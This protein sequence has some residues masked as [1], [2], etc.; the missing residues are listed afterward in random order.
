MVNLMARLG[1][2]GRHNGANAIVHL[3]REVVGRRR[4][5]QNATQEVRNAV[6]LDSL[7]DEDFRALDTTVSERT[8]SDR[9]F[10]QTLARLTFA[11]ARAKGF[12]RC[13]VDAAL[14]LDSLIPVDDPAHERDKLLRDAYN[15]AQKA[16]YIR[17]G[18]LALGRLGRRAVEAGDLER[19]RVLLHQQLDLGPEKDD[20]AAEVDSA[21]VLGDI[22]RRENDDDQAQT[23]YRRAGAAAERLEYRQ[24]VAEALVRQI[25]TTPSA[26]LET[27]AALQHQA[28]DAAQRTGDQSLEAR[29]LVGLADTLVESRRLDDATPYYRS[30]L[31]IARETGDLALEARSVTAL[32]HAFRE[33]GHTLDAI[34]AERAALG[35]EERLGNRQAA[36]NWALSLG[37]SELRL[38]N[39]ESAIEAFERARLLGNQI[40]DESIEQ[41]AEGNLGIANTLLGRGSETIEHLGRAIDL[42]RR[43]GD[44]SQEAQWVSSLGEAYWMFGQIDDAI[45]V[46]NDAIT[47]AEATRSIAMQADSFALLGQIYAAQRE[48]I[49]ARDCYTRAL[50]LNRDLGQTADQVT[51]LSA[52]ALLAANAGQFTQASQLFDQALQLA[53]SSNDRT[54]MTVLFGR[55]GSLAQKR[56]DMR[57]ALSN[58]QRA[59]ESA[60]SVGDTRLLSRALQYLATAQDVMGDL[61]AVTT[62][63]RAVTAADDASD[64]RGGISMR[65]N[66][67]MLIGRLP[68]Q[69]AA[70]DAIGWLSDAA[71]YAMEAG[72]EYTELRRQA[73]ELIQ[74]LGGGSNRRFVENNRPGSGLDYGSAASDA[75]RDRHRDEDNFLEAPD[76][77]SD[78]D[79]DRGSHPQGF[80][81]DRYDDD[82][83]YDHDEHSESRPYDRTGNVRQLTH[84]SRNGYQY[85]DEDRDYTPD[86]QDDHALRYRSNEQFDTRYPDQESDGG[87]YQWERTGFERDDDR[88]D[89]RYRTRYDDDDLGR[90]SSYDPREGRRY[91]DRGQDREPRYDDEG[92]DREAGRNPVSG[93]DRYA[94]NEPP[95]RSSDQD[96]RYRDQYDDA[97]DG[98]DDEDPRPAYADDRHRDRDSAYPNGRNGYRSHE[99]ASDRAGDEPRDRPRRQ[100]PDSAYGASGS[101][102]GSDRYDDDPEPG[103]DGYQESSPAYYP[104]QRSGRSERVGRRETGRRASPGRGLD[105]E[106]SDP[107]AFVPAK[108]RLGL[109]NRFRSTRTT[110]G[111]RREP[112]DL[113]ANV[114]EPSGGRSPLAHNDHDSTG[115][116]VYG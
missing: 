5:I 116:H 23:F 93:R 96:D 47:L 81:D 105:D 84:S 40:G 64:I 10:A 100:A 88:G 7:S 107:D 15:S 56:G 41:R 13:V 34:E 45:R 48:T 39:A 90:E 87:R 104:P 11:A 113:H 43:S 73:E 82:E 72:P 4:T 108:R 32:A 75:D 38:R 91:M 89:G 98:Y 80:S 106:P 69:G 61:Q 59:V 76:D 86:Q 25:D 2:R 78:D 16:S 33:L 55:M 114:K 71:N 66:M 103:Y 12:D 92:S 53:Q 67:G 35:I 62:Y 50:Q 83:R 74:E 110:R 109:G 9:E 6:I 52:L 21:L 58:F 111:S 102:Y 101:G 22:L 29:I 94:T 44:Q 46:T 19:A 26:N 54:T 17:G 57:A 42:A 60:Q 27:V 68:E 14:R 1:G 70:E 3:A 8:T 28:L 99:E 85:D 97:A 20:T 30:A 95:R 77:H 115:H 112:G 31:S 37:M 63:E 18:R 24:G 36:A 79:R 65:L 49:R 51:T